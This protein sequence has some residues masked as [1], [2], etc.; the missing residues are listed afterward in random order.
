MV[1]RGAESEFPSRGG[2]SVAR[3]RSTVARGSVQQPPG[4]AHDVRE[5]LRCRGRD[6]SVARWTPSGL[7]LP[8]R[9]VLDHALDDY[10]VGL[11]QRAGVEGR[12]GVVLDHQLGCFGRGVVD[13]ELDQAQGHVDAR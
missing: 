12:L 6:P 10:L 11:G 13:E 5:S 4:Y 2:L 3:Q 1:L 8:L 9:G 7:L